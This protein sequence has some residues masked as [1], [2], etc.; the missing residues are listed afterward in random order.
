[1]L[2]QKMQ[3]SWPTKIH[4]TFWISLM[5]P[6]SLVIHLNSFGKIHIGMVVSGKTFQSSQH[7]PFAQIGLTLNLSLLGLTVTKI[8]LLIVNNV[9]NVDR[10][11]FS[12]GCYIR[13]DITW[14]LMKSL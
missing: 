11:Y 8:M 7:Y 10:I 14:H 13:W 3:S 1:M 4:H 2:L 12:P 9:I 6:C 5:P